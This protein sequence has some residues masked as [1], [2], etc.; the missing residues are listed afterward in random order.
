ME[1]LTLTGIALCILASAAVSRRIQGTII[2]LPVVYMA[3]GLIL[4]SLGLGWLEMDLES[5]VLHVIAELTLIS[6][7]AS[8]ASRINLRLLNAIM[9]PRSGC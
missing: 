1:S 7:L 6:V 5:H 3:L 4:G 9:A 2:T 8:D